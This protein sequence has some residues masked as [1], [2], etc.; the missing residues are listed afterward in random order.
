MNILY[1][2]DGY[3]A[4]LR[5]CEAHASRMDDGCVVAVTPLPHFNQ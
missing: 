2:N 3:S 4:N 1:L 5:L